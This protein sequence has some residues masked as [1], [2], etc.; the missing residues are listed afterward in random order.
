MIQ[1]IPPYSLDTLELSLDICTDLFE[2]PSFTPTQIETDLVSVP[3]RQCCGNSLW[4]KDICTRKCT[5]SS[6]KEISPAGLK[7]PLQ[8]M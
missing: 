6:P 8:S 1:R 5:Y 7:N 4:Q 3:G 2:W